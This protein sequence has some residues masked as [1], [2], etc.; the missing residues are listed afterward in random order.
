MF[1]ERENKR[2]VLVK[3]ITFW[4][5]FGVPRDLCKIEKSKNY[6]FTICYMNH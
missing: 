3:I 1:L 5:T 2:R 6:N 4:G